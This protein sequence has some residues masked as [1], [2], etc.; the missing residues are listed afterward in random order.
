M[1]ECYVDEDRQELGFGIYCVYRRPTGYRSRLVR[2]N[3]IEIASSITASTPAF[4]FVTSV[5]PTTGA[6][7]ASNAFT[8]SPTS[9]I[10]S[11]SV[12]MA[13]ESKGIPGTFL[14]V[15]QQDAGAK[16][17]AGSLLRLFA[18]FIVGFA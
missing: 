16:K 14:D 13:H 17:Q 4:N 1:G 12:T 8:T 11:K 2:D 18:A 15:G 9:L 3:G 7:T 6:S 10:S 5:G